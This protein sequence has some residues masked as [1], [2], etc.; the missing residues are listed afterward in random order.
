MTL[1]EKS[2]VLFVVMPCIAFAH[3]PTRQKVTESIIINADKKEV[4]KVV[5]DFDSIQQWHGEYKAINGLEKIKELE[6]FSSG[7]GKIE[8]IKFSPES[9]RFK[10]RLKDAGGI[11]VSNYSGRVS[12]DELEKGKS[13]VIMRGAFYRKY[14]NN[15]PPPGE[16]DEAAIEAVTKI[17]KSSLE[18]LKSLVESF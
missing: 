18:K 8:V 6:F 14:V 1:F 15:D 2:L 9:Q 13:K 12:V 16:D 4:W 7:N 5:G 10:Y 11:P 3:G 17:Y